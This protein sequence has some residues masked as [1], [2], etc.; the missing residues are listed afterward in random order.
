MQI[1]SDKIFEV[2]FRLGD[3]FLGFYIGSTPTGHLEFRYNDLT[4]LVPDTLEI[5]KEILSH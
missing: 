2:L 1:G 4:N 5:Q 3:K